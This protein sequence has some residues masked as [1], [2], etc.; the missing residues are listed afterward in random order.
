MQIFRI[1][2]PHIKVR[3]YVCGVSLKGFT[4][5][6]SIF[7]YIIFIINFTLFVIITLLY[8]LCQKAW[9]P[10]IPSLALPLSLSIGLKII[11]PTS[12]KAIILFGCVHVRLNFKSFQGFT[13]ICILYSRSVCVCMFVNSFMQITCCFQLVGWWLQFI[14]VTMT[15][16]FD[17][18]DFCYIIVIVIV[19][20]VVV[21]IC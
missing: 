14:S 3:V 4:F 5:Y 8:W 18:L 13:A 1:S 16:D 2:F 12:T 20:A 19:V 10:Y 11:S 7:R 17:C 9:Y 15:H 6:N 21:F